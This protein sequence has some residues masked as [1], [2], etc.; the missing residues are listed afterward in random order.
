MKISKKTSIIKAGITFIKYVGLI[1][2]WMLSFQYGYSQNSDLNQ[3]PV[4]SQPSEIGTRLVKKFLATPHSQYGNTHPIKPPTQITYPD[5]CA[6]L[7][8][9]WFVQKNGNQE[10]AGQ[11]E[12]RF[13]PLFNSEKTLLPVP[14]HVDNTVFGA[15]PLELYIQT[16]N[17]EYLQ[18]G[19]QYADAQW[20]LPVNT[21]PEEK[22]WAD[23]G[24]SW[25]TRIWI[26]DMF[27]ITAIQ[28]QAY[29][30]TKDPKYLDRAAQEMVLYLKEIQ[31][32]N[33]LFF[34]APT[35]HYFWCRGNG[36]MAVGM[37][38]LLR[39]LPRNH[40]QRKTIMQA[41]L[42]MMKT[43]KQYQGTDGMWH[44]L[45]D[46]PTAWNETSGSAMFTYAFV[47]GVK[48]GWLDKKIY[49]I[50]A[51]KA[52][53]KLVTYINVQDELI[54][55]CEGTNIKDDRNHYLNRKRIIGDLHG[56]APVIWCAAALL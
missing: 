25:Q 42:K 46:D 52:W 26:D 32:P 49:G 34:H 40:P 44:Q 53:L 48:N 27:M 7:G 36:W 56:Q 23:K 8:S 4:G 3:F 15:V 20:T 31:Q 35:A 28:S 29:R 9:L 14:N 54:D 47:T 12:R 13:Q 16:H 38:E 24:Y 6:W 39:I 19:L 22:A 50:A 2:V 5:V 11:L 41:Y 51:R 45:I 33:G 55:V 1:L 43:L 18:L 10:L 21:K 37:A 30:A 17:R